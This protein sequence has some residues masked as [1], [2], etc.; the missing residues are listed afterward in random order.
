MASG[1]PSTGGRARGPRGLV[2]AWAAVLVHPKRFFRERVV[3]GDQAPG[4]VFGVGVALLYLGVSLVAGTLRVPAAL[5]VVGGAG[6]LTTAFVFLAVGLLIAPATLHLLAAL[7]T[8]LLMAFVRDRAGVSETVQ[9]VAY[10]TAPCVAAGLPVPELRA[11]C[12]L[13]GAALLAVGVRD[14]HETTTRRAVAATVIP[15]A[16]LFGY[17]FG[18]FDAVLFLLRDW[19]II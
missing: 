16:L 15:A 7:Q 19:Y 2:Q 1:D 10:A 18:G 13:Y 8:L 3:P 5:P 4:L 9:V 6:P 12:C 11:G 14:V 17:G